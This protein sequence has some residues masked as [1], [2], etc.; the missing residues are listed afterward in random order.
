MND[1][2]DRP[3]NEEEND[4]QFSRFEIGD[5]CGQNHPAK[6]RDENPDEYFLAFG[7]GPFVRRAVFESRVEHGFE[8]S[9]M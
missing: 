4:A 2:Q 5:D 8:S 7:V 3:R 1:Q 9:T 6:N